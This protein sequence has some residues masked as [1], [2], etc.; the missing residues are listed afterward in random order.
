VVISGIQ[1][2]QGFAYLRVRSKTK[3]IFAD[4]LITG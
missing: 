4:D 3:S 2:L 1:A